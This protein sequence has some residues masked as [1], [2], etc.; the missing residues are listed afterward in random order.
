V[1]D[2]L[3]ILAL[4]LRSR[5]RLRAARDVRVG[6]GVRVTVAPGARV[7]LEPGASLGPESRID[8]VGGTVR[9]RR[10]AR[11]GERAI[12]VSHA[13]VEIGAGAVVGDWAAVEGAAPT[14][15][16]VEA[17]VREQP[18]LAAPVRIGDGAVLGPH[19]ALGPGVVVPAGRV[20]EPYA[21]VSS[22]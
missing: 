20:V 9:L 11:L 7:I 1:R 15:A 18:L 4:R 19:A 6:P 22:P 14:Y 8:A 13:G 5:G 12:V 10:G 3:R 2:A 16:D 21:V 17:P